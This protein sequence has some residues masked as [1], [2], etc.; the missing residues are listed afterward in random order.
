MHYSEA[1]YEYQRRLLDVS[2]GVEE[3][4]DELW[5]QEYRATVFNISREIDKLRSIF[6]KE[7]YE[8]LTQL[9]KKL[10]IGV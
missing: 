9:A 10:L 7:E 3:T 4:N 6:T 5:V 1:F 2:G 8:R